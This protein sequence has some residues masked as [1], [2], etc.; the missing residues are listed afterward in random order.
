MYLNNILI[1]SKNP[2]KY[3]EYIWQVLLRLRKYK[4]YAK[5]SKYKFSVLKLEFL[6]F[7]VKVDGIKLDFKRIYSIIK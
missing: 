1:Y 3:K 7:C 2:E 5:L 6:S 4:L